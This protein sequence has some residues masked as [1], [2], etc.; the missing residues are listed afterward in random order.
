MSVAKSVAKSVAVTS[1][2]AKSVPEADDKGD[3]GS[4]CDDVTD[5][6][7]AVSVRGD[8]S[9]GLVASESTLVTSVVTDSSAP[10]SVRG[11]VVR[12]MGM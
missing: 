8:D 11:D 4:V 10:V 3:G 6:S 12:E 7:A 5:K 9:D 2:A 1:L